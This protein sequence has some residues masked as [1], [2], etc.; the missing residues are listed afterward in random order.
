M[1][2]KSE[3]EVAQACPTLRDPMDYSLLDSSIHG[4]FQARALERGAI[5]FSVTHMQEASKRMSR[6]PDRSVHLYPAESGSSVSREEG[7]ALREPPSNSVTGQGPSQ[8]RFQCGSTEEDRD[9]EMT[10]ALEGIMSGF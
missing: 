10:P 1:K 4:I 5:A 9:R 3:S 6:H 8:H 2:V 7:P